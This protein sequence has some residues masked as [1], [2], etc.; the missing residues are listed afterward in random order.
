VILGLA[1]GN[2]RYRVTQLQALQF[3][4]RVGKLFNAAPILERLYSGS[5]IQRRYLAVSD[6][7]PD[8]A[9]PD[10]PPF[11]PADG[12]FSVGMERR[13][14]KFREC[15]LPLASEVGRRAM[16]EAGVR[17]QEVGLLVLVT[18]TGV[19]LPALDAD[20][21]R[22]LGL[23]Q[24]AE[25]T[26][27]A[28]MGCGAAVNGF[29]IAADYVVS[30]PGRN[31]LLVTVELPSLHCR[32]EDDVNDAILH[33]IFA[34]GCA[35]AVLSGVARSAAPPGALA[36][37]AA[38]SCPMPDTADGIRLSLGPEGVGCRLS[39][40]LPEYIRKHAPAVVEDALAPLG[41]TVAD[42]DFW[43]VHPGGH[44][45]MEEAQAALGLSE[46][47]ARESWRVLR[48]YGNMPSCTL[49]FVL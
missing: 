47:Q 22:R 5:Q 30:H 6:Y 28:F 13:C 40:H 39:K 12:S 46:E 9:A 24:D 15:A 4:Q 10:D 33:A 2:P 25:R 34:D 32:H 26:L 17:P 31:A 7:T 45:I 48:D 3:T 8:E 36:V 38:A 19:G 29:R 20:L 11:Y 35:A 37:A 18:T 16:E 42:V 23:P 49:L 21:S 41:L 27:M 1:T 44:R 14:E 43:A